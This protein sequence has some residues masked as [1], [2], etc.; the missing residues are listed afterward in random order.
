M[1]PRLFILRGVSVQVLFLSFERVLKTPRS[2]PG[3]KSWNTFE[4][5]FLHFPM[6][7]IFL[8]LFMLN[9]VNSTTLKT[10]K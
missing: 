6:H 9:L 5:H 3:L 1:S 2:V 4:N 10:T 7:L 8:M